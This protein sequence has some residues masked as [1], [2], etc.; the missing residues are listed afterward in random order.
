MGAAAQKVNQN[1]PNLGFLLVN[2]KLLSN[3]GRAAE[4][5]HSHQRKRA[6][7]V[8]AAFWFIRCGSFVFRG[9]GHKNSAFFQPF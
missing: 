6:K 2:E 5:L 3:C 9:R 8:P 7:Q 4:G 1:L